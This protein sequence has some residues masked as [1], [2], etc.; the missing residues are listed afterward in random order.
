MTARIG[1]LG[2]AHLHVDAYIANLDATGATVV[3]VTDHDPVRGRQWATAHGVPWFDSPAEL[4]AAGVDGVVVC[5]EN[6]R[7]LPLVQAA[8]AAGVAVLCEKPLATT[9]EDSRAV[10]EA[11]REAGVPL[12]T[13]FPSRFN[14][15]MRDGI[16]E[17]H[18]GRLGGVLSAVGVNQ[19]KM[20]MA[21]R[22]WFVDPAQS[23]G[24]ALIDHVV[25]L[26][27]LLRWLLGSDPVEVYAVANRVLHGQ[28]VSVETGGL[29]VLTFADGTYASIDSSWSR[30]ERYP[31]WGGMALELVCEKGVLSLDAFSQFATV[32]GGTQGDLAWA[33]WGSD[34][35]QGMI[36]EFVS[37]CAGGAVP[38]V[39]G[40]DG[41]AATRIAFA[42][43]ESARTGQPVRL[44]SSSAG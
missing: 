37:V 11:C 42:A 19:G 41:L 26:A 29:V 17:V 5:S 40:E 24:G 23:G 27:D 31:T 7:H 35:N 10:V 28:V 3:G 30:P 13:A 16:A 36:D 15:V 32:Y 18:S 25:H 21:E 43:L 1:L 22:A 14:P 12:M 9:E 8:A 4:L 34:S 20:P 38:S 39:T 2:V 6:S 33:A 44:A